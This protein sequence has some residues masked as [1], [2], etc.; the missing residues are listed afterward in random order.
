MIITL[1]VLTLKILEIND[2]VFNLNIIVL[3][4]RQGRYEQRSFF[5]QILI[6]VTFWTFLS[7]SIKAESK[8]SLRIAVCISK[9]YLREI[10]CNIFLSSSVHCL[11]NSG[12]FT[13]G[14]WLPE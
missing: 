11:T 9:S 13:D 8:D 2:F 3:K 5:I 12:L 7:L 14:T 6:V 1:K 10:T 4:T